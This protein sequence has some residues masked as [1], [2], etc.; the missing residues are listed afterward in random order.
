[1]AKILYFTNVA[2]TTHRGNNDAKLA[3][4]TSWW[5]PFALSEARGASATTATVASIA[6]T[7]VGIEF[8]SG[9]VALEW[10]SE[11]LSADFTI[12]GTITGNLWGFESTMNDNTAINFVVD[13]IDG[14]TGAITQI[15]KSA[16]V[17]ELGTSNGANNFTVTPTSTACK[18]GDRIRIRP[19]IDD[20]GAAMIIGTTTFSY[21]GPTAAAAGDSYVQFTEN[22]TFEVDPGIA[23]LSQPSSA[24]TET[25][26][27]TTGVA[28]PA[29]QIAQPFVAPGTLLTRIA[30]TLSDNSASDNL[31]VEVQTD[32]AG[33]PSGTV[34]GTV[35]T[36]PGSAIGL[37]NTPF[38]WTVSISLTQAA[39]YWL[40]MRRSG[41]LSDIAYYQV[42]AGSSAAGLGPLG[43]YTGT[44]WS[45]FGSTMMVNLSFTGAPVT[46]SIYYLTDTAETINPG[47]ATEKKALTT[48]GSGSVNAVTNTA[49]G[50]TAGIQATAS[51]GGTAVEW[52][53][54]ALEAVTFGG[55]AKINIRALE[56]SAAANASLKAEIA[57][58]AGDGTGATVWGVANVESD[59]TL[60]GELGTA[61]AAKVAWVAGDDVA[62]T[63]GQ[64]LRFRI[65]VDDPA[66]GPLV[67]G[68]TVTV[69]YNGTSAAAAGDTYVILPVTV[70]EQTSG[71]A[72]A[73]P[74][75][76][77]LSLADSVATQAGK[78]A[79]I[80]DTLAVADAV[81]FQAA[82]ARTIPDTLAVADATVVARDIAQAVADTLPL[83]DATAL[84]SDITQTVADTVGLADLAS[85]AAGKGTTVNDTVTVADAVRFDQTLTV[86]DTVALT[87]VVAQAEEIHIADTLA[88]TDLVDPVKTTG[89]VAHTQPVTDTV[90]VADALLFDRTQTVGDTLAVADQIASQAVLARTLADT[91]AVADTLTYQAA[92]LRTIADT[93]GV[94]DLAAPVKTAGAV[95]WAQP[96][97]DTVTVADQIA[98]QSALARLVADAVA[99]TDT[100]QALRGLTRDLADTLALADQLASLTER[101]LALADTI[102]LAD[103]VAS[104]ADLQ[105]LLE[106]AVAIADELFTDLLIPTPLPPGWI[107]VATGDRIGVLYPGRL[108]TA[109]QTL[110][111][112]TVPGQGEGELALTG[113][114]GI[115]RTGG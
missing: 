74:V 2:A 70:V 99:V 103:L 3:G 104:Q 4:A 102:S 20:A 22:L 21:N 19:F 106:D 51:A 31:I 75:N 27:Q 48:R 23:V 62:I 5:Q 86:T 14:A 32:A 6:G 55:K 17:T 65:Y 53:T 41:A 34:A 35:A 38:V 76:D 115:A 7:T 110:G 112:I 92:L 91:V 71:T 101:N 100:T 78:A 15:A 85:T 39:T 107:I 43:R 42:S 24:V 64:R 1:M 18:R 36:V 68:N 61:D 94:G 66:I 96:V 93:V 81:A 67:T 57:V 45:S 63:A 88:L 87:D 50:P 98:Y 73:Q 8:V 25:F 109:A 49:A 16:R 59:T 113:V 26:G 11:P 56:S 13:K 12:S 90:S 52:Y 72:W 83:A 47:A 108:D 60:G 46:A 114:G 28:V 30:V 105:R 89:S 44:S 37:G 95:D 9:A 80:P 79:A 29:T 58:V 33:S 84:A 77:T 97:T 10:L 111:G 54:P 40:V 69:S 82:F